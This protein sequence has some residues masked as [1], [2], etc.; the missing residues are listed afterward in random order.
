MTHWDRNTGLRMNVMNY[1]SYTPQFLSEL[2]SPMDFAG[3][4]KNL[5]F[6]CIM[7]A[8][9]YFFTH[10]PILFPY[11]EEARI[12]LGTPEALRRAVLHIANT[13]FALG[14]PSSSAP[15]LQVRRSH[16]DQACF[17]ITSRPR[18]SSWNPVET[19]GRVRLSGNMGS[20]S[21]SEYVQLANAFSALPCYVLWK[22]SPKDLLPGDRFEDIPFGN[23]TKAVEW[24]PQNDVLGHP[25]MRGYLCHGGMNSVSEAAYHGVPIVG[26]PMVADQPDNIVKAVTKG[27]GIMFR[28]SKEGIDGDKLHAALVH[29]ISDQQFKAAAQTISVRMR[30]RTRTPLQE[31]ADWIQHVITTGGEPY[32][33]TPENE[34]SLIE[35]WNLDVAALLL[36][37][38]LLIAAIMWLF[39]RAF[40]WGSRAIAFFLFRIIK[41]KS[42]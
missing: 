5:A 27:F 11:L 33:Q 31:A 9:D 32:L 13:D 16:D 14:V 19:R 18:G 22:I 42:D 7:H 39:I 34:M 26:I 24:V 40:L 2:P 29:V 6:Y 30:A 37:A 35:L 4:L 41:A 1:I 10:R 23:N 28:R 17:T 21:L 38:V 8:A 36:V 15:Q 12:Q 20:M 3:R 25:K